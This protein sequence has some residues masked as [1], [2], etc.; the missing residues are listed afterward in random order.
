MGGVTHNWSLLSTQ[1]QSINSRTFCVDNVDS[2]LTSSFFCFKASEQIYSSSFSFFFFFF[3]CYVVF[4]R[5]HR[6]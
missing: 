3:F 6:L 1:Q 5:Y 4:Y 2:A